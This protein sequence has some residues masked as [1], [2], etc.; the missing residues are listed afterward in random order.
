[1]YFGEW[2]M[3]MWLMKLKTEAA[4]GAD[5]AHLGLEQ[6]AAEAAGAD[7]DFGGCGGHPCVWWGG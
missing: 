5:V 7:A 4:H 3:A 6:P 1:M 2:T